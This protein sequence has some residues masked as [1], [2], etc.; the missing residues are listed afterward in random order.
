MPDTKGRITGP[1]ANDTKHG[2]KDDQSRSA[3]SSKFQKILFQISSPDCRRRFLPNTW[4]CI[5]VFLIWLSTWQSCEPLWVAFICVFALKRRIRRRI[6][7]TCISEIEIPFINLFQ[8]FFRFEWNGCD[9][10][11]CSCVPVCSRKAVIGPL[12]CKHEL[13]C[14]LCVWVYFS[15]VA[16]KNSVFCHSSFGFIDPHRN[17]MRLSRVF[18]FV[19]GFEIYLFFNSFRFVLVPSPPS[20][21]PPPPT[22]R[23]GSV[24]CHIVSH[25]RCEAQL[26]DGGGGG[27]RANSPNPGKVNL[28]LLRVDAFLLIFLLSACKITFHLIFMCWPCFASIALRHFHL[29]NKHY[30]CCWHVG[31]TH[32]HHR[33]GA[34]LV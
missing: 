20:P 24:L 7:R 9:W 23:N 21:P 31:H 6:H 1:K 34:R 13:V 5:E 12:D 11:V 22:V 8:S 29:Y 19:I 30:A 14:V 28:C 15:S 3:D 10:C 16:S 25:F 26:G 27:G 18:P 33:S 17:R 32:T 4:W 2:T